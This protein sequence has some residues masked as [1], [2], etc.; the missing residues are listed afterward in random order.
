M[1]LYYVPTKVAIQFKNLRIKYDK[2]T[3]PIIKRKLTAMIIATDWRKELIEDEN[4]HYYNGMYKHEFNGIIMIVDRKS[5]RVRKVYSN[6]L[7]RKDD[8]RSSCLYS[9]ICKTLGLNSNKNNFAPNSYEQRNMRKEI[10]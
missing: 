7:N 6:P 9:K 8:I 4:N 10:K 2:L 3:M 5:K 1:C